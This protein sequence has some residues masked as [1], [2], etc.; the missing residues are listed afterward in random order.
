MDDLTAWLRACLDDDER[1]ANEAGP[2]EL[3]DSRL[4]VLDDDY[5]H[6]KVIIPVA[7]VLDE[8]DVKRRIIEAHSP[9]PDGGMGWHPDGGYDTIDQACRTCG[10]PDEYATAWPCHTI[11]LLAVPYADRDGYQESWRP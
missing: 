11:R 1:V 5:R 6:D 2:N 8:I 3:D 4:F 9:H 10:T 7:R